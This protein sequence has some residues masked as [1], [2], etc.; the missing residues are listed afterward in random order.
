MC[1]KST[2]SRIERRPER[3]ITSRSIPT[4]TPLLV[5]VV[6]LG[7]RVRELD[8]GG[9]A[10]PPFGEAGL[11]AVVLRERREL[12]WIVHDERGLDQ[13]GLDVLREQ[14]VHELRPRL[15]GVEPDP[16]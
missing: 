9:E 6:Q 7:E 12:L 13:V 16:A 3:I 8:A 5:G 10:L 1:G 11:R 14:L 15:V 2:T 4:P